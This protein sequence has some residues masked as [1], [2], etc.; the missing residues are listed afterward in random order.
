MRTIRSGY[1]KHSRLKTLRPLSM[2]KGG[3]QSGDARSSSEP[4]TF[5]LGARRT[6][7]ISP[8]RETVEEVGPIVAAG[9]TSMKVFMC[10]ASFEAFVPQFTRVMQA[11]AEAGGITLIH[12]EDLPTIECCTTVLAHQHKMDLHHYAESRPVES[13]IVATERPWGY[14][15]HRATPAEEPNQIMDPPKPTA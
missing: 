10:L 7:I 5:V 4:T 6:A 1:Q 8:T 15:L 11:A 9:Q 14:M 3:V 2:T 13:E 12:C